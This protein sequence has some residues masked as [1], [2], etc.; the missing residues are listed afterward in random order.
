MYNFINYYICKMTKDEKIAVERLTT[1]SNTLL[2]TI[3]KACVTNAKIY[4]VDYVPLTYLKTIQDL[5]I[6]KYTESIKAGM[7]G[8]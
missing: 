4:G 8:K 2:N 1:A 5:A 3:Y 6:E 7:D